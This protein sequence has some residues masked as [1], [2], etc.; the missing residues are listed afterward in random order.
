MHD[1]FNDYPNSPGHRG[2]STSIEA[3][4]AIA[5][6]AP[7]I[8]ERVFRAVSAAGPNGLTVMEF[9]ARSGVDDR[10]AQPRFS[11]LRS[12]R[13]IADSGQRRKNPS[14]VRAIVWTLPCHAQAPG[15]SA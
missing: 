6:A 4:E 5:P 12:A 9:V 11:E 13:R 3:A 7:V 10:G 2:V 14:G 1:L 15:E 8:R